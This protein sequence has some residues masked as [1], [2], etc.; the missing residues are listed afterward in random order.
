MQL[1]HQAVVDD[2]NKFMGFL[3]GKS[4]D[5]LVDKAKNIEGAKLFGKVI[6]AGDGYLMKYFKTREE[7][8]DYIERNFCHNRVKSLEEN[9][10]GHFTLVLFKHDNP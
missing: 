9:C 1:F 7:A 3:K 4:V 2:D 10:N 6:K 8:E 5:N